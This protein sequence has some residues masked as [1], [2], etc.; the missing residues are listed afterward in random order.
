MTPHLFVGGPVHGQVK[1]LVSCATVLVPRQT[2]GCIEYT[3]QQFTYSVTHKTF[4]VFVCGSLKDWE[5]W[6]VASL[7]RGHGL[8]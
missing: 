2:G 4:D 7:L 8:L 1:T 3:R 5:S 6:Q